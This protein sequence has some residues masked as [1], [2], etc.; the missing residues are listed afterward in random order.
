[1]TYGGW[2]GWAVIAIFALVFDGLLA[3]KHQ[4]TMSEW[5]WSVKDHP[6]IPFLFGVLAGHLFW[7]K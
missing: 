1:M 4:Q 7:N 6:I 2:I 3:V 5:M